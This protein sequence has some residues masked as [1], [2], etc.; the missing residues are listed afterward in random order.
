MKISMYEASVPRIAAMLRNLSAILDKAEAHCEAKKIKPEALTG[1]RLFP[2]MLPL[3][4]QVQIASDAAKGVVA[5]LAGV[6]V[7]SFEDSEQTFADLRARIAK[8]V[9]FI[10]GVKPQQFEGS[11]DRQISLKFG[12]T[13]LEFKGI[14]YLLSF[15]I[16][17][18]LF[19]VVTAYNILRHNGVEIGKSDYLGGY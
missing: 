13:P 14:D 4:K 10:E 17:H 7:P 19:H 6:E 16:P 8:T 3:I 18:F 9:T 5:R 12:G 2:D 11:E 15:S 1:F